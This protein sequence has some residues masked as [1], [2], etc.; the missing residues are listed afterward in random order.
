MEKQEDLLVYTAENQESCCSARL[1]V[2]TSEI[3][4]E[5]DDEV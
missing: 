5:L 2:K 1:Y 3:M 4:D